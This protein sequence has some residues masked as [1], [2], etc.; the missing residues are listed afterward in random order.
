MNE[1]EKEI[2]LQKCILESDGTVTCK[3][4]K[5]KFNNI[6]NRGIKPRRVVFEIE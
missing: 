2:P 6:Q 3:I 1:S 5:A 4:D